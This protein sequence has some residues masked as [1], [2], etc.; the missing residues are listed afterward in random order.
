MRRMVRV[1][2]Q[3]GQYQRSPVATPYFA[4]IYAMRFSAV[5]YSQLWEFD[6]LCSGPN[7]SAESLAIEFLRG[8]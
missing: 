1:V 6:F 5:W 3:E 7:C 2:P 4:V 8:E